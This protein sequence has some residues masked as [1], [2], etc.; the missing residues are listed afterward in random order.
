MFGRSESSRQWHYVEWGLKRSLNEELRQAF[1][2]QV[3]P[4]LESLGLEIPPY[5]YNRQ[6]M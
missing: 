2:A 4:L 3:D 6:F 5:T 1:V